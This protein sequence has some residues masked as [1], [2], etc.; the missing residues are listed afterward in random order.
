MDNKESIKKLELVLVILGYF[1]FFVYSSIFVFILVKLKGR[2]LLG[3]G[4]LLVIYEIFFITKVI[5]FSI[6]YV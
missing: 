4:S 6:Y 1:S 2:L 5:S 3:L